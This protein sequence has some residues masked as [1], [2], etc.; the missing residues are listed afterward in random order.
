[1]KPLPVI[2]GLCSHP[3]C[4]GESHKAPSEPWL[5]CPWL[6][7]L[8][9]VQAAKALKELGIRARGGFFSGP[10]DYASAL[11]DGTFAKLIQVQL[12]RNVDGTTFYQV[13]AGAAHH[14]CKLGSMSELFGQDCTC[15]RKH[16]LVTCCLSRTGPCTCL[17][18]YLSVRACLQT[19]QPDVVRPQ[20]QATQAHPSQTAQNKINCHR[21]RQLIGPADSCKLGRLRILSLSTGVQAFED[22]LAPR[23][24]MTGETGALD[25][26]GGFLK[27]RNL[28]KGTNV[29]MLWASSG[30]LELLLAGPGQEGFAKVGL[31]TVC[32]LMCT[33]TCAGLSY[34]G[35][36]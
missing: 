24:R 35:R 10:D 13:P 8:G 2:A 7:E 18:V 4:G 15:M 26:F 6:P 5:P 3:L 17:Q 19:F 14:A 16:M 25:Q 36:G 9:I 28:E 1:M 11:L 21:P 23:L 30:T 32:W 27:S 33:W 22:A 20:C 34:S 29:L 12:V 31:E